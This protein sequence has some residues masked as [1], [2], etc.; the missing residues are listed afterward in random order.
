L[1]DG[2]LSGSRGPDQDD[3]SRRNVS[4]HAESLQRSGWRIQLAV[5]HRLERAAGGV[6]R[7]R[8]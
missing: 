1:P 2:R 5:K 3:R 8:R 6:S 4:D 7:A